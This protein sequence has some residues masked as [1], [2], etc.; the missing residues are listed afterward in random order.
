MLTGITFVVAPCIRGRR[1]RRIRDRIYE[2]EYLVEKTLGLEQLGVED[3]GARRA[4][5][6]VVAEDRELEVEDRAGAN[7]PD[8]SRHPAAMVDVEARLGA[9]LGGADHDRALGGGG[10]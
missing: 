6:R 4:P 7:A 10:E 5:D 2:H 8:Q 9:V 3:R 1:A